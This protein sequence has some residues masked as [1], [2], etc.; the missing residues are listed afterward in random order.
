MTLSRH[1]CHVSTSAAGPRVQAIFLAASVHRQVLRDQNEGFRAE[2]AASVVHS[3]LNGNGTRTWTVHAGT[4]SPDGFVA[5]NEMLPKRLP[6]KKNDKVIWV[7]RWVNEPHTITFPTDTHTDMAA[8]CEAGAT[9]TPATPTVIPPT[10]PQDFTCGGPPIEIEFDGGNGVNHV[11]SKATVSDSGVIASPAA[12]AGFGLPATAASVRWMVSFVGAARTTYHLVCQVHPG[13]VGTILVLDAL[14]LRGSSRIVSRAPRP[15]AMIRGVEVDD[16]AV[17][18]TQRPLDGVVVTSPLD[19]H[20]QGRFPHLPAG[21]VDDAGLV[22]GARGLE[23]PLGEGPGLP[24]CDPGAHGASI[25]AAATYA[26]DPVLRCGASRGSPQE[27]DT[28]IRAGRLRLNATT[29]AR[30]PGRSSSFRG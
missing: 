21:G 10:G 12:V 30:V 6:I 9:D 27:G 8:L 14:L 20:V 11:T 1:R 24:Q 18:A 7:S 15:P 22:S 3:V 29:T 25:G 28:A 16:L 2:A 4:G 23:V 13:M 26:T 19:R 5:V 17:R